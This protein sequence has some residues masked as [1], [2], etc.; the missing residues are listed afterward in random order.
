MGLLV[1]PFDR[2][3]EQTCLRAQAL[4]QEALEMVRRNAKGNRR[5]INLKL[6]KGRLP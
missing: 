2:F 4:P 6:Q 3:S 5:D 1:A